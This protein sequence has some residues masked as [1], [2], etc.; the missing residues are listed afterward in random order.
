M[1]LDTLQAHDRTHSESDYE[2]IKQ[3]CPI[4]DKPPDR[5]VGYRGGSAHRMK[6]GVRC[7]VWRCTDCDL[8]FPNPMPVPRGGVAQHY[9]LPAEAYF[10]RHEFAESDRHARRLVEQA[11][12]LL[13]KTGRLLDVGSGRGE[14]ARAAKEVGWD[15]T[16]I[17]PSA[18]FANHLRQAGIG[19]EE[20]PVE[21]CDELPDAS[22]N[23]VVLSAVL[24]HLYSPDRVTGSI[25]RLLDKGGILFLD[26]PNERGLYARLGNLYER[27][28]GSNATV[29]LSPTFA[30]YHVFG[31]SP[32]SLRKLLTKH[33]LSP[34]KWRV[35]PGNTP[36]PRRPG[37]M[38]SLESLAVTQVNRF[39]GIG[40]MGLFIET[41]AQKSLP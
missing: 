12:E 11:S 31:F 5:F 41:W 6:L 40:Q 38:G 9:D 10:Y 20:R 27:L 16:A 37:V 34:I 23:V 18:T 1:S 17:E 25:A 2:W 4:C 26:V 39:S 3:A 33:G 15:V 29:N 24:E 7:E 28:R 21:D 32:K 36:L 22:F 30:P 8:T 13:G 35:Y 14:I 19:V